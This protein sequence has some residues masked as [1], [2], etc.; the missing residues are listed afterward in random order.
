MTA[1]S[2]I[3]APRL[4]TLVAVLCAS[5]TVAP[6]AMASVMTPPDRADGLGGANPT[7]H[8]VTAMPQTPAAARAFHAHQL[9]AGR[10]GQQPQVT[11]RSGVTQPPDRVDGLG[12]SRFT[13]VTKPVLASAASNHASSSFDWTAAVLGGLAGLGI[14][15]VAMA[16]WVTHSRRDV[17][18]PSA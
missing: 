13:T 10:L 8:S 12:S 9:A 4:A 1:S 18:L 11:V 16:A 15:L 2:M 5:L 3:S 7:I 17:A 6:S 14:A